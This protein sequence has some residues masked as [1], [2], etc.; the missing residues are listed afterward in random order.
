MRQ[1]G[2]WGDVLRVW[3]GCALKL[4]CDGC[5]TT[6]NVIKFINKKMNLLFGTPGA[7]QRRS[8]IPKDA[9][10]PEKRGRSPE[11]PL[12]TERFWVRP[13]LPQTRDGATKQPHAV[14]TA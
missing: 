2:G 11:R 13:R 7:G 1:F 6:I 3:D 10:E 8:S 5:C 14:G 4:G 12:Q 9:T